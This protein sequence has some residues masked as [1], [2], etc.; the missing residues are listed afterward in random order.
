MPTTLSELLGIKVEPEFL[1]KLEEKA[2][3]KGLQTSSYA[4]MK[5]KESIE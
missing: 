3:E 5:L 1:E 4:R 2:E